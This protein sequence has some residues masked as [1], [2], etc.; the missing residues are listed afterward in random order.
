MSRSKSMTAIAAVCAIVVA[1]AAA[2][3]QDT[4]RNSCV[5]ACRQAKAQCINTCDTHENP[6]EC[7]EDCQEA[8]QDCTH[9]CR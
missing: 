9:Q 6:V 5:E 3:A 2:W 8:A 4:D 7:D 1:G